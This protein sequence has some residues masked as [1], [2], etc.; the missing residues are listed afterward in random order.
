MSPRV[1]RLLTGF[2]G[3]AA[4]IAGLTLLSRVFGFGRWLVHSS[5]VGATPTGEAYATAN[6]MPNVLF[7]VV[8]GGALA[9]A[10]VPLLVG[11]LARGMGREVDRIA[12][13]LL[14]WAMVVLLPAAVLLAVVARPL[15][16]VL[17]EDV[18]TGAAP[19]QEAATVDLAARLLVVFAPQVVLYGIGIVLTGV[20]QAQRRFAWPAAAPLA[21]TVVVA[22][23]YAVFGLL[24]GR[25]VQD[26][27]ALSPAAVAVLAWGTTGG[28]AAMS[29]L[30]VVPV[31]RSGVRLRPT[32][33]FPPGVARRARH[34]ALAG[35]G[36][37]AAQ[38]AAVLVTLKLANSFGDAGTM[39]L[40]QYSQAVYLLPYAVLVVPLATASFPRLAQHAAAG[41]HDRYAG[42]MSLST[43]GV[44]VAAGAGAAALAAAAPA[45]GALFAR[46]DASDDPAAVASAMV[47][48]ITLL[49]PGLLGYGLILHVSRALF[50][51]ERGRAAV[52]GVAAGWTAVAV[53]SVV[54][55]RLLA[56]GGGD[57]AGTLIGLAAGNTV[58][59]AVAGVVLLL[60]LARAAGSDA[61]AG[62]RRTTVVVGV[63]ALAGAVLGR[64]VVDAVTGAALG[65]VAST[66]PVVTS[67]LVGVLGAAVAAGAVLAA[68]WVTDGRAMRQAL[69]GSPQPTGSA[70]P[71]LGGTP[72]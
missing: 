2:A 12:S 15:V 41:E 26:P 67:L 16:R 19:G 1:G 59:M 29:L 25:A 68:G 54:A 52:V 45:V 42:L 9:G 3:A 5:T 49:A 8:A 27:A 50:A 48:A 13:A 56:P 47:P 37:L 65:P 30:L 57:A 53:A 18:S 40:F 51:L 4:A 10:V 35:V 33:R 31:L 70:V 44:L 63:A 32:L 43:R 66:P 36:G 21:S 62:T 6:L 24:A 58:G 55:V 17:I 64:W 28:V 60:A 61:L 46:I 7:E 20:L 11:P 38:Q 22:G 69:A 39:P 23:S 72:G 34:L 14:T 71:P